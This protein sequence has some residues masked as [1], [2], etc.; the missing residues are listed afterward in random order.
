MSRH[1][2]ASHLMNLHVDICIISCI[3]GHE[4]LSTTQHYLHGMDDNK[5]DAMKMLGDKWKVAC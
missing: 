2:C 3:L 4:S 1:T 5:V